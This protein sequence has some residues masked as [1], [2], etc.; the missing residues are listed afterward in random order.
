MSKVSEYVA[1]QKEHN[2]KI[3]LAIAGISGD[4]QSLK[5]LIEKLQNSP[6]ELS[7]EDQASLDEL[8]AKAA[9]TAE[10]LAALDALNVPP[11]PPVEEPA[12]PVA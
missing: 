10:K 8:E 4:V 7:P 12:P 3:D 1:K 5:D 2:D 11:A 9:S 6:S